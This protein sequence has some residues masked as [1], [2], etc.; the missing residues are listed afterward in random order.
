MPENPFVYDAI[1]IGSGISGGWAANYAAEQLKK[2]VLY[3]DLTNKIF[4]HLH[5]CKLSIDSPEVF[6]KQGVRIV[7]KI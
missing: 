4:A 1:V 5:I 3:K 7:I 2:G 6:F